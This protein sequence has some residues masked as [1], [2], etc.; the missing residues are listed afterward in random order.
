[1]IDIRIVYQDDWIQI[2]VNGDVV[3]EKRAPTAEDLALALESEGLASVEVDWGA[4]A[5]ISTDPSIDDLE[6]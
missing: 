2:F 3:I 1:M 6:G 5:G 4:D